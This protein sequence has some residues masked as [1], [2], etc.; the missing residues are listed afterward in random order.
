MSQKEKLLRKLCSKPKDMTFDELETLLNYL[1]YVR[2]NKGKTSGSRVLFEGEGL[3]PVFMH[4]PHTSGAPLK[5]YQILEIL[6]T[7]KE[8]SLI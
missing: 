2:S 6:S 1:G 8:E 3:Q 5:A 7:L 4:K